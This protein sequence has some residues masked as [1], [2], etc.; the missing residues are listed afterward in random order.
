MFQKAI[1]LD[2]IHGGYESNINVVMTEVSKYLDDQVNYETFCI[3]TLFIY[4]LSTH[5]FKWKMYCFVPS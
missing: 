5:I 4:T 3:F 2:L 1:N